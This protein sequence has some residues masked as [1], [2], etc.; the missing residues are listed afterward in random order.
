MMLPQ[1]VD[2]DDDDAHLSIPST[3]SR[4]PLSVSLPLSPRLQAS[5]LLGRRV[6][7]LAPAAEDVRIP[8]GVEVVVVVR[9]DGRRGGRGEEERDGRDRDEERR[10]ELHRG[11]AGGV[12]VSRSLSSTRSR[13]RG[14]EKAR[15]RKEKEEGERREE[16]QLLEV[17]RTV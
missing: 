12:F 14:R 3:P 4:L 15:E 11:G 7:T 1:S 10:S 9:V 6:E 13:G 16:L 2:D 5:Y 17:G 8:D